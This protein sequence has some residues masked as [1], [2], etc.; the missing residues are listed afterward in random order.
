MHNVKKDDFISDSGNS[1]EKDSKVMQSSIATNSFLTT[2]NKMAKITKQYPFNQSTNDDKHFSKI[3]STEYNENM[4]EVKP[5]ISESKFELDNHSINNEKQTLLDA[6]QI[7][8][9]IE[10]H[11]DLIRHKLEDTLGIKENIFR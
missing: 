11:C 8:I 9:I 6:A 5:P 10:N 7:K 1:T 4:L 2:K 3:K